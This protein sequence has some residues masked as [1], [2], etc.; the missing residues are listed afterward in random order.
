MKF[1]GS[2]VRLPSLG[3]TVKSLEE[4]DVNLALKSANPMKSFLTSNSVYAVP[5]MLA[6]RVISSSILSPA[7][8]SP[9]ASS[10]SKSWMRSTPKDPSLRQS[11]SSILSEAT[12]SNSSVSHRAAL[13]RALTIFWF[14]Q[15]SSCC[16]LAVSIPSLLSL[17]EYPVLVP[18][19]FLALLSLD[20]KPT[21]FAARAWT[22]VSSVSSPIFSRPLSPSPATPICPSP[23]SNS[24]PKST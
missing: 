4:S 17:S 14:C 24:S 9:K 15:F 13:R 16:A 8:T 12:A 3:S 23:P 18:Q 11:S 5:P 19:A 6:M 1:T 10:R 2:F 7:L 20:L 21:C 22:T